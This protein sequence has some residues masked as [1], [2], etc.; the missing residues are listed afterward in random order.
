MRFC[1][2]DCSARQT[3]KKKTVEIPLKIFAGLE[4]SSSV[5]QFKAVTVG[6]RRRAI[7]SL[8]MSA[9]DGLEFLVIEHVFQGK[10]IPMGVV[11]VTADGHMHHVDLVSTFCKRNRDKSAETL[12]TSAESASQSW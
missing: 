4:E 9:V 7:A 10:N 8:Y 5:H 11:R 6:A 2:S 3:D 1:L 12:R